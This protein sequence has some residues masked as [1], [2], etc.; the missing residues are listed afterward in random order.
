MANERKFT[1]DID[2]MSQAEPPEVYTALHCKL[3][4]RHVT[5]IKYVSLRTYSPPL[6][7]TLPP[8]IGGVIGAC[9]F[10]GTATS[11][12]NAGPL[13]ILLAYLFIGTICFATM[14]SPCL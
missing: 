1:C 8:S 11:L 2:V 5:M 7:L 9:L 14:V 6:P 12:G 4:N 13:G 10:F 3:K